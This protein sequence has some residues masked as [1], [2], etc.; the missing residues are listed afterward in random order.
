MYGPPSGTWG[1]GDIGWFV[2]VV[3][4]T[5]IASALLVIPVVLVADDAFTTDGA[6]NG[7]TATGSWVLTGAQ[8]LF[9]AGL[10]AWPLLVAWRK[11]RGL[12]QGLRVRRLLARR[13]DWNRGRIRHPGGHGR[14]DRHH[15]QDARRGS[16][17]GRSRRCS[18]R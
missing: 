12:A 17:V 16:D 1:L 6:I 5:I 7:A 8:A 15:G 2:L 18:S 14:V 3:V 9:F 13:L 4:G 11:S 10:A